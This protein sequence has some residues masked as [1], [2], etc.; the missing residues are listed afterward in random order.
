M[1][2][3]GIINS[4]ISQVL[5]TFGHTDTITIADCGLPIFDEAKRIDLSLKLGVPSFLDVLDSIREDVVVEE[6]TIAN[7]IKENNPEIHN[8]I[9]ERFNSVKINYISHEESLKN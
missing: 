7:E 4:H 9:T 3:Q 6:I 2:K 8:A 1:K 5:S